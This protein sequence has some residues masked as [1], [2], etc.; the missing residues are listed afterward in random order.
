MTT[1]PI[2]VFGGTGFLGS[3]VARELCDAG[4][5][6][7]IVSRRPQ[8][9]GWAE[10]GDSLELVTADIASEEEIRQ[11][12]AG[13]RGGI[14]A[15]SLYVENKRATFEDVHVQGA[16]RLADVA[17]AAGVETFIQVSGL[18][19][20]TASRSSYV[21]ARA[22]GETAVIEAYPKAVILRP[23]VLFGPD[24][25]FLARLADLARLPAIPLFGRGEALLQPV[26]V[27]DV[28]RA[29]VRLLGEAAPERRL[30]ELGGP[31]RLRYRDTVRL[32]MTHLERERP[33]LPIPFSLWHLAVLPLAVLPSPPLTRDQLY[34]L[35]EDNV[36]GEGVGTFA[37]L[38][39]QPR[40]LRESL[41]DCLPHHSSSLE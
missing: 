25:V 18:G 35:A 23:S 33:L 31:D 27:V 13:A 4:H 30:Y 9:P 24:D 29:M 19:V 21:R 41:P 16:G 38:N 2:A 5:A 20:D 28:A 8:L 7:R 39:I 17:R 11:A 3:Q 32:V 12:V 22:R 40:S 14:N 34:M 15:V 10:P 1:A 37:D 36:V 26:H 6:V